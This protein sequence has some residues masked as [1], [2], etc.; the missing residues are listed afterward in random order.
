MLLKVLVVVDGLCKEHFENAKFGETT[1]GDISG[2]RLKITRD[3]QIIGLFR[4]WMYA[5]YIE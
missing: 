5:R 3:D 4:T 1:E 2:K